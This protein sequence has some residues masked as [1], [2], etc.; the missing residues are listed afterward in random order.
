M[1]AV[2]P[3]RDL[4][5]AEEGVSIFG[6]LGRENRDQDGDLAKRNGHVV[7]DFESSTTS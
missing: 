2:S 5:L 1:S 7:V 4:S 3:R 6:V